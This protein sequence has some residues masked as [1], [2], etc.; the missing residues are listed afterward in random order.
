[1]L[2][3]GNIS[4]VYFEIRFIQLVGVTDIKKLCWNFSAQRM[5]KPWSWYYE[6]TLC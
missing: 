3:T 2:A 4:N 6:N 5:T 1:V